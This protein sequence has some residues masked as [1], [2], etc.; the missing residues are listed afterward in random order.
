[1][2]LFEAA[3]RVGFVV[4]HV[5]DGEQLSDDEQILDLFRQIQ[6]LQL[7][8]AAAHRGV[9][10]DQFAD[11]A[12]VDVPDAF[13]VQQ[14]LLI[15]TGNQIANRT[16][17]GSAAVADAHFAIEIQNRYVARLALFDV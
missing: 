3:E 16:A 5:E 1:M 6:K 4:I 10:R 7:A 8:A 11:A 2:R 12:G 15:A 9:V 13:Q 17:K 14:K